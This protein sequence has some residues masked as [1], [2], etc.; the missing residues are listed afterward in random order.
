[1]EKKFVDR[2]NYY[3]IYG[4][5]DNDWS[6]K[7]KVDKYL[8][9]ILGEISVYPSL[10]LG[11]RIIIVHGHQGDLHSDRGAKLSRCIVRNCWK[12]FQNVFKCMNNRA[13]ENNII[14]SKRDRYLFEWAK[15]KRLLLIAGHTHRGMFDTYSKTFQLTHKKKELEDKLSKKTD[16]AEKLLLKVAIQKIE[17]IIKESKEEFTKDKKISRLG[18]SPPPCYFN[19][20]CCVHTDGITGIEI[21]QGKIRLV[22]WEI[23]DTTCNE[24]GDSKIR[25]ANLI[26]AERK[27]YQSGDLKEILSK[28]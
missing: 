15:T 9:P 26:S 20:G 13:A 16:P 17:K 23:S 24:R 6:E 7:E 3:R 28:I 12:L 11:E 4:N 27:I 2:G 21:D 18:T 25:P 5:H 1:M 19:D 8:K 10:F 14:R 22:K